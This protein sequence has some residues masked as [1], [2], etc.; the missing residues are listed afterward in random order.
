[1]PESR[2]QRTREVYTESDG[3]YP[4]VV[5]AIVISTIVSMLGILVFG[6]IRFG[7]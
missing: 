1:M 3:L 5:L 2:L 6:A 7:I 4:A